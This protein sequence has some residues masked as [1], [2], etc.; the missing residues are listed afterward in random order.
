MTNTGTGKQGIATL[1]KRHDHAGLRDYLAH[2]F[3][4]LPFHRRDTILNRAEA[5]CKYWFLQGGGDGEEF[6]KLFNGENY[7][8]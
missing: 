7:S 4:D 6:E 2:N 1:P 3:R 8:K 5:A